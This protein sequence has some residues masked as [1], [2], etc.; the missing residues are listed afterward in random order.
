MAEVAVEDKAGA[1]V[2]ISYSRKDS[3]TAEH[4]RDEL[5]ASGFDAFLDVHDIDPGEKWKDRLGDLIASAEKI[6]FLISP[7]SVASDICEWE[8]DKAER[9]GKSILPVVVRETDSE[10]IPGRLS[11]INFIFYR[12]DEER[13][14]GLQK[15]LNALSTDLAWER[16]KT[17]V[18][19]LAMTWEKAGRPTR[20]LT[21]REDAIRALEKWRDGHPST[22]P[23]PTESQLAYV[24]ES[25]LRFSRRQRWIRGGLATGLAVMTVLAVAAVFFGLVSEERRIE[26]EAERIRALTAES[27]FLANRSR[28]EATNNSDAVLLALEALPD[29]SKSTNGTPLSRRPHT[30]EAEEALFSAQLKLR[31]LSVL[32]TLTGYLNK[33]YVDPSGFRLAAT[34]N[35]NNIRVWNLS[36]SENSSILSGHESNIEALQFSEDGSALVSL[37]QSGEVFIWDPSSGTPSATLQLKS[38]GKTLKFGTHSKIVISPNE[39]FFAVSDGGKALVFDLKSRRRIIAFETEYEFSPIEIAFSPDS[40]RFAASLS[41]E[42]ISVWELESLKILYEER[43]KAVDPEVEDSFTFPL[44]LIPGRTTLDLRFSKDGS[45]L[46]QRSAFQLSVLEIND[47]T[48]LHKIKERYLGFGFISDEESIVAYG[49]GTV[50]I[51]NIVSGSSELITDVRDESKS[52]VKF[53]S[54]AVSGDKNF[55]AILRSD[56][57]VQLFGLGNEKTNTISINLGLQAKKIA[58]SRDASVIVAQMVDETIRKWETNEYPFERIFESKETDETDLQCV[59]LVCTSKRFAGMSIAFLD[60]TGVRLNALSDKGALQSWSLKTGEEIRT[61]AGYISSGHKKKAF[62][63]TRDWGD[64]VANWGNSELMIRSISDDRVLFHSVDFDNIFD[65]DVCITGELLAVSQGSRVS[66][67]S[68]TSKEPVKTIDNSSERLSTVKFLPDCKSILINEIGAFITQHSVLA[69]HSRVI[70][71]RESFGHSGHNLEGPTSFDAVGS[72]FSAVTYS[73]EVFVIRLSDGAVIQK[74]FDRPRNYLL[75]QLTKDGNHLVTVDRDGSIV[76]REVRSGKKTAEYSDVATD[77]TAAQYE[78]DSERVVVV[79]SGTVARIFNL[80]SDSQD[81]VNHAKRI[82]PRCLTPAQREKFFL[83]PEPERWCITGAG[84]EAEPDPKKWKPKWPY[85]TDEWKAWLV[86]KD[87]GEEVELPKTSEALEN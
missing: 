52:S 7:D 43:P 15:L 33:L 39:R 60:S 64:L 21:W 16:E 8:I 61:K 51:I 62:L 42:F 22:S 29:S 37:S 30:E 4:L 85:R 35:S 56:N 44:A 69:E 59:G 83:Q 18:N 65:L 66:I 12:S 81:L 23:A 47:G 20:L 3:G 82:V 48:Y 13:S 68:T 79:S 26:A 57:V 10:A 58:L 71:D 75:V 31:E 41:D 19:D 32:G 40:S 49:E 73:G 24:S 45:K 72:V 70:I 78:R 50:K 54:L 9:L 76:R 27:R 55:I 11:D 63:R 34:E 77:V 25:R 14:A 67:F 46:I 87:R 2:F 28:S 38:T 53:Q 74:L 86:A 5:R 1:R 80:F 84:L 36:E 17:R 6:V